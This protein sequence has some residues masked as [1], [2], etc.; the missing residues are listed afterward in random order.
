MR[1]LKNRP[2]YTPGQQA[3]SMAGWTPSHRSLEAEAAELTDLAERNAAAR[4]AFQQ[5]ASNG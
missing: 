2:L 5:R 4:A 1:T 3:L